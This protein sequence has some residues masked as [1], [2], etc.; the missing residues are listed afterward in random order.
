MRENWLVK[1]AARQGDGCTARYLCWY[2][3][4]SKKYVCRRRLGWA[5]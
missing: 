4:S 5:A 3:G 1:A 2:L